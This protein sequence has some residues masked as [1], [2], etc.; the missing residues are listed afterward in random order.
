MKSLIKTILSGSII[1]LLVTKWDIVLEIINIQNVFQEDTELLIKLGGLIGY[2]IFIIF[3]F[4]LQQSQIKDVMKINKTKGILLYI[5][6]TIITLSFLTYIL[7]DF[8][9]QIAM[10]YLMMYL[11]V[12][13]IVDFIAERMMMQMKTCKSHTKTII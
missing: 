8:D 13:S 1:A 11:I 5:I 3:A 2:T 4:F 6:F 12:V 7:I 10:I 9:L